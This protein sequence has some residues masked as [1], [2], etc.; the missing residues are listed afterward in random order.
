MQKLPYTVA[1]VVDNA[2]SLTKD[3]SLVFGSRHTTVFM[4]HAA[5]GDLVRAFAQVGGALA[6]MELP[7]GGMMNT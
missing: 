7:A 6:E 3:G 2:P 5:T 4:V 1:E